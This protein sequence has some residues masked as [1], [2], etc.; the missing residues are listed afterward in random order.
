MIVTKTAEPDLAEAMR[1]Y[2]EMAELQALDE[3]GEVLS[4]SVWFKIEYDEFN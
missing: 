2:E 1:E 4:E 3:I